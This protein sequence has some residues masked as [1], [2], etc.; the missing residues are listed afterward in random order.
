MT[1]PAAASECVL[2]LTVVRA[3]GEL[4]THLASSGSARALCGLDIDDRRPPEVGFR[5]A[6]CPACLDAAL[7]GGHIA[8]REGHAWINL[9]RVPRQR[10]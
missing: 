6:G 2:A 3:R 7:D 9:L 4:R 8:A 1:M 5:D 10:P